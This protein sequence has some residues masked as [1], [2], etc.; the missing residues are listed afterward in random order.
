[1]GR[2]NASLKDTVEDG[3]AT[4][5]WMVLTLVSLLSGTFL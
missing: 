3:N 1:M 2:W 5:D 4:L